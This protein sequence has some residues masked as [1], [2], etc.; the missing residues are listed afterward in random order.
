MDADEIKRKLEEAGLGD[1]LGGWGQSKGGP[2]PAPQII[3]RQR[4]F[5][6]KAKEILEAQ[7]AKDRA[8]AA[9]L[10]EKL[11]RLKHGG[12]S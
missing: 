9:D 10:R 1:A 12:G 4:A 11:E 5:L 8:T 6:E 3:Q 2:R 7:L